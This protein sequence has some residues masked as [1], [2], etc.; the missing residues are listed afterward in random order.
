MR[1][2]RLECRGELFAYLGKICMPRLH[3]GVSL[4][5]RLSHLAMYRPDDIGMRLA[6]AGLTC[7]ELTEGEILC[8]ASL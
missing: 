4:S 2:D 8:R 1:S 3:L 5:C 7:T 6:L